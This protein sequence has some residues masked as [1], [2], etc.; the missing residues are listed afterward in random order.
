MD[1]AVEA[2]LKV[3]NA[4]ELSLSLCTFGQITYDYDFTTKGTADIEIK[5]TKSRVMSDNDIEINIE[6]P[7]SLC[8]SVVEYY[9]S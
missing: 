8:V 4:Q 1:L 7:L 2:V 5:R 9:L 3:P 6:I